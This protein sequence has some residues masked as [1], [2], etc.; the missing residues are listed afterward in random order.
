M[1]YPYPCPLTGVLNRQLCR[2]WMSK[3]TCQL[4][5]RCPRPTVPWRRRGDGGTQKIGGPGKDE[6]HDD[7]ENSTAE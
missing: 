4:L 1:K 7:D 5:S 2:S 3:S 6:G